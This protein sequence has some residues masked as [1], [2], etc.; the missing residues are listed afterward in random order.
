M[1][2]YIYIYI[3]THKK[4]HTRAFTYAYMQAL[5]AHMD[6]DG[7]GVV[8]FD[9]YIAMFSQAIHERDFFGVTKVS[10]AT[11]YLHIYIDVICVSLHVV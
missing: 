4:R 11:K 9:D 8:S 1:Y 3:Q 10:S 6:I 7:D 2:I 5:H